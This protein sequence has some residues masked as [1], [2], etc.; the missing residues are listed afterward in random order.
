M[1]VHREG[2]APCRIALS[3]KIYPV[4]TLQWDAG[5]RQQARAQ[6]DGTDLEGH[7]KAGSQ[8]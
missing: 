7:E 5:D 2:P 8:N 6:G 3:E 4:E 1:S